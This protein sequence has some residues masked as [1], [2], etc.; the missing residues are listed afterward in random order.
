MRSI[1]HIRQAVAVFGA[2]N[3]FAIRISL[4]LGDHIDDIHPESVNPLI[5]PPFHQIIDFRTYFCITPVQIRLFLGKQMQVIHIRPGIIFPR[6]AIEVGIPVVGGITVF[7]FLPDIIVSVRIVFGASALNE[8]F[9]FI[10]G[11]I[12]YQIQHDLQMMLMRLLQQFIEI[13]QSAEFIHDITVITDI[14]AI[15][16]I[17]RFVDWAQPQYIH[18]QAFQVIQLRDD[19]TQITDAVSVAV[20]EAAGIYLIYY[21][22]FPPFLI[23]IVIQPFLLFCLSDI[24]ISRYQGLFPLPLIPLL[25]PLTAPSVTPFTI[26]R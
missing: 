2:W 22:F 23:H 4:H 3:R 1:H 13:S 11:M 9:V 6:R 24:V 19:T 26:Y 21:A 8:P 18:T 25:Q 14:V 12:H 17:R 7:P 5:Q 10:R 15:I 20:A 16:I